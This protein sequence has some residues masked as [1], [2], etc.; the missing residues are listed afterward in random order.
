MDILKMP[1]EILLVDCLSST[2]KLVWM[3]FA[4]EPD[5]EFN[6][7]ICRDVSTRLGIHPETCRLSVKRLLEKGYL[8]RGERKTDKRLFGY[9]YSIPKQYSVAQYR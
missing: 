1:E 7:S 6:P 4:N 5:L 3:V 2:D 9:S 8:L